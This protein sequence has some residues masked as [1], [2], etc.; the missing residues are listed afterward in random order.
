MSLCIKVSEVSNAF[1]VSSVHKII[2]FSV[3]YKIFDKM[4]IWKIGWKK[5]YFNDLRTKYQNFFSAK[6]KPYLGQNTIIS[7]EKYSDK[8]I[9]KFYCQ[10]CYTRSLYHKYCNEFILDSRL[11]SVT[12]SLMDFRVPCNQIFFV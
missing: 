10:E 11:S 7:V 5:L 9:M 4:K 6:Q 8:K 12:N 3:F 1:S 2:L